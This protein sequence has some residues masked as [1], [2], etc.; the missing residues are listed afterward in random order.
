M[1]KQSKKL[2][3]PLPLQLARLAVEARKEVARRAKHKPQTHSRWASS[4][5]G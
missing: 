4:D 3:S 5:P 2:L 1:K